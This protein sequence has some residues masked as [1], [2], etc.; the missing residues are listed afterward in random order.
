MP[1]LHHVDV[2]D[3]AVRV[4][5]TGPMSPGEITACAQ[6]LHHDPQIGPNMRWL[7]DCRATTVMLSSDEVRRLAITY[8]RQGIDPAQRIAV[9]V[10][11]DV[12]VDLARLFAGYACLSAESFGVFRDL[13]K[14]KE[15]LGLATPIG[16]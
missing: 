13:W 5:A 6:R 14:A 11:T 7:I 15:W 1:I 9:V 3:W 2:D 10:S 12:A 8:A 16:C 4:T